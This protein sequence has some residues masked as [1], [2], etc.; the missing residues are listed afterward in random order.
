MAV[1]HSLQHLEHRP[2]RGVARRS[3]WVLR[4]MATRQQKNVALAQRQIEPVSQS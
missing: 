1:E 4:R 3:L 2:K